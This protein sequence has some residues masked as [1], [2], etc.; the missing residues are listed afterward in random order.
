[1]TSLAAI[2]GHAAL[3]PYHEARAALRDIDSLADAVDLL[4]RSYREG[5]PLVSDS[6]YDNVFIPALQQEH[7]DHPFLYQVEPEPLDTDAA[8]TLVRHAKPMLS[9]AKAY[10]LKE[11]EAY[12]QRVD[13][14]AASLGIPPHEV[15]FRLTAKLDGIAGFDD[16]EKLLTR[17]DGLQGRDITRVLTQGVVVEGDR[18]MGRGELVCD[19]AFFTTYLGPNTEYAMDHARNF[20]AGFAGSDTLKAHHDLALSAGAIRFV[21]FS[22]L[23]EK[24]V[25]ADDLRREWMQLYQAV[26]E[27]SPYDTDGMVVSV[28][29][30][31][32]HEALGATNHHE[33]GVL[34]IKRRSDTAESTVR[35]VRLTTGRTGRII[36]TLLIQ[37]V[38]LSGATVSKVTAHTAKNLKALGLGV[39]AQCLVTRSGEVIP[40]LCDVLV[41][42][43]IPME[44]THCP[45]CGS[46][47]EEEGEHMICPNTLDCQ[48]QAEAKLRHWFQTLGNVDLFG[49]KTITT[50][51]D[52]DI[53]SLEAIYAMG[54]ED[55]AAL[56]FG[57]GQSE[58]LVAQLKRS[59]TEPVADWRFL[60]AFGIRHLGKGDARRL[61]AEIPLGALSAISASEIAAI[62]GFGTKTSPLIADTLNHR[63]EHIAH[64]LA[65]G[66]NLEQTPLNSE[67][68]PQGAGLLA[69]EK[70]VFTG[71][72]QQGKRSDMEAQA[73]QL[74]ADVQSAVNGQTTL[75][76]IGEKAGSKLKKAESINEKAGRTVVAILTEADYLQRLA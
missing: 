72:M 26:I 15:S 61:L 29:H 5:K 2:K 6:L 34:A 7:P 73:T 62:D 21:P 55:F 64:M 1:M 47:A 58:N 75:L 42:A 70:V 50:L 17:G 27:A 13:K 20:V 14:M 68:A 23:P 31:R 4:N 37:P 25:M 43:D 9:T 35:S 53:I 51:V 16:G 38:S 32:L 40:F 8:G 67:A 65:L 57:P 74:G 3:A 60:A 71:T 56:G 19:K 48:A 63:W 45:S 76:V 11:L 44:V 59:R 33:R 36:P 49:P 46:E 69:G 12:L 66:F 52:A 54:S 10:S 39:G 30:R 41:P 18:G 28:N 22:T 24:T